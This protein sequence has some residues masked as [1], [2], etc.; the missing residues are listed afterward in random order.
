MAKFMVLDAADNVAVAMED[1]AKGATATLSLG[2]EIVLR[3]AVPFAH[4]TAI[5]PITAGGTVIKYGQI[6]GQ[7]RIDIAEGDYVHVHNIKSFRNQ[8]A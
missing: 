5:L 6:I 1:A 2:G 4:K 8:V 3:D 7:A